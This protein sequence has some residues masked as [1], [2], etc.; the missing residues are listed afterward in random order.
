MKNLSALIAGLIFGTG[1]ALAGM[2]NPAKVINFFD[3]FGTFDP[4]LIFVMG[5]GMLTA[6]AGYALVFRKLKQPLFDTKFHLPTL[7]QI[8]LPLVAGSAAFGIGWGICGACP[9]GA[10]G[11]LGLGE[12]R[13]ILSV[14]SMFLGL[15]LAK[16]LKAG[17]QRRA[18]A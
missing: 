8:D 13:I 12:P 10:I 14:V 9:G 4:S 7:K 17:F 2:G 15:A 3:V 11:V 16:V 6:T 1:I 18:A 5:G